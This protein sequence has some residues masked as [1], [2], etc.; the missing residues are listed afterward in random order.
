[1]RQTVLSFSNHINSIPSGF[2]I[3]SQNSTQLRIHILEND[4]IRVQVLPEGQPRLERTWMMVNEH[5][6]MPREGRQR[7]DLSPFSL[8]Q[9]AHQMDD[10][11]LQFETDVLRVQFHFAEGA[12]HW[13][14]TD[15]QAFAD[16][17][18][19][20]AYAH[21]AEGRDVFHYLR[22]RPDEYYYGF[23]ER[24]GPLNKKG[25]RMR[26]LNVDALG[27]D[28]ESGDP[29]YKHFPFYIT[30]LPDLN[31]AYGLLYDN[32]ATT[33]FDM[34]KEIDAFWGD[35]RYYH[36]LDGDL[37]YILIYG[38][39]IAEVVEKLAKLTGRPLLPPR[40]SLGYLGSTMQY[41]EVPN[42]QESLKQFAK[43]C[44]THDIPCDLFHLSSGYTTDDAGRR[45]VFTWNRKRIPD[46]R[47]MVDDFHQAHM[48]LAPNI[49][50]YLLKTHPQYATVAAKG[51]FIQQADNDSPQISTFWSGGAGEGGEGAY[52]DFTSEAGYSWWQEQIQSALLD[53]GIDA[54][55]N[56]NNE[57]EIWDDAALC[58]GFGQAI[59]ISLARPL[60]TLLMG[61]ASYHA[62]A[63][64]RPQERPF[65]LSRSGCPGIQ[66][67]AQTWSGDNNT[68]WKS[69]RYNIPMGLGLSL[70]GVPNNG[71][72]VGGFHG[73]KP[74]AELLVRWVQNGIFHLRFCIHSWN[75]DNTATEPWMYP[76]VLPLIREAIH[77]RYRLIPY[78]YSLLFESAQTGQPII[79]PLV[80]HFPDCPT[81][82]FDFM[83]G[84]NLLVASVLEPGARERTL[85]LPAGTKWFDF[86]TGEGYVGGQT[87]TVA[88]PLDRIPLF[89]PAGGMLP[90]GKLMRYVGEQADDLR[91]LIVFPPNGEG[92]ASFT[93]FEDD[94]ISLDYQQGAYATVEIHL[95][96]DAKSIA[97]SCN[98][99]GNL[100]E[101]SYTKIL[102]IFPSKESR[103]IR[104]VAQQQT[105]RL[106]S[107]NRPVIDLYLK[108]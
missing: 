87:I 61:H 51:G 81:E 1:M 47:A 54:I 75:I 62:V 57:F 92:T 18:P 59:P 74:D 100:S 38:P 22:R 82:S 19:R 8:P 9:F 96:T 28:A 3:H 103:A 108:S 83:L 97:L 21:N 78:L 85:Y 60:Q 16:D 29:L 70:S 5:G 99:K 89:V 101:L 31:I 79:R 71:H 106:D 84:P 46:P 34:G 27:Y 10:S 72:D 65:V 4:L 25:L 33:I 107:A 41:T 94:G 91:E 104:V 64:N 56:D 44:A 98:I 80:Y 30:Y 69:L 67:Y 11:I 50:P 49:K 17:L 52:V 23:G 20:R 45:N 55:W 35:Y 24:A 86:H 7:D 90:L 37:D 26:M 40:W 13:K 43:D 95:E 15:G 77:F 102:C 73:P 68:S 76:D 66:R 48:H 58:A 63:Q 2:V 53:Y 36:A 88:A 42:A 14:T 93:L 12:L 105:P 39:T 6:Q 32:L